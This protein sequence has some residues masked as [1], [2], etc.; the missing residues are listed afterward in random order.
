[1][2]PTLTPL[3]A[4]QLDHDQ[5]VSLSDGRSLRAS[6]GDWLISRGK[7]VIDVVGDTALAT[8]YTI[9]ATGT[10]TLPAEI[11]SRIEQTAGLGSTRSPADLA[12]AIE[13]LAKIEIGTVQLPFTPGQLEEIAVRA[14]KRGQTV[15]QALQATIDRIKEDLFWRS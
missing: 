7:A 4:V 11:C 13:R 1:M 8:R 14:K 9:Q 15:Q 12:A 6:A 5:T 10:L 3:T 2:Q